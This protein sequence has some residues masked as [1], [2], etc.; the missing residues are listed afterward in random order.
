M[1][2]IYSWKTEEE[3][4]HDLMVIHANDLM[5]HAEHLC[6]YLQERNVQDGKAV[7]LDDIGQIKAHLR[8]VEEYV[9]SMRSK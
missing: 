6:D 2:R 3:Q 4:H 5:D 9:K 1:P 8:R 7:M